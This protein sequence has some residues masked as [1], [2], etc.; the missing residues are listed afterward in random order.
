L[1]DHVARL[2]GKPLRPARIHALAQIPKTRNGKILRRVVRNAYIGRP[3]GDLSSMENP[4]S[5]EEVI[6]LRT[7]RV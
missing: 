1:S 6:S 2:L 7:A 5:I 4:R 3:M